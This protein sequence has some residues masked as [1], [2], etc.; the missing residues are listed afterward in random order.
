[1]L[2]ELL[3]VIAVLLISFAFYKWVTLNNDFFKL[4]NVKYMK[5]LI[6]LGNTGG[7]YSN[8][9][10]AADFSDKLYRAFPSES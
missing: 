5:P 6:L 3:L 2:G 10:T 9:Y 7:V 4:R 1:M 8:K